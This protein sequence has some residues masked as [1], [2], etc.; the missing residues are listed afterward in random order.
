MKEETPLI[1]NDLMSMLIC[2]ITG[3]TLTINEEKTELVNE[4]LGVSYKIVD[5]VPFMVQSGE[6]TSLK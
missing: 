1:S 4:E 3:A 6:F 5:G 2:P